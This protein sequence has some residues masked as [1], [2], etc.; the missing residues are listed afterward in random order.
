MGKCVD[1]RGCSKLRRKRSG[2]QRVKESNVRHELI[3]SVGKLLVRFFIGDDR[4]ERNFAARACG[5]GNGDE[6][7][8]VVL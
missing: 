5:S 8:E 1:T 7:I 2:E 4:N 6:Q 3:R